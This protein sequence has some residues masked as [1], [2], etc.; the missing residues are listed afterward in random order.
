MDKYK[1]ELTNGVQQ[2]YRFSRNAPVSA[3]LHDQAQA[4]GQRLVDLINAGKLPDQEEPEKPE[5][6]NNNV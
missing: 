4:L 2:L 1:E 3:D 6:E 5:G